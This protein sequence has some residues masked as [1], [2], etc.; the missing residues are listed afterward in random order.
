LIGSRP[1]N[2]GLEVVVAHFD[3]LDFEFLP[4][5]LPEARFTVYDKSG[6]Y[7]G[8]CVR[9][10]N[11]GREGDSY[12][13]HI[14]DNYDSLARRT[15][16]IQDDVLSHRPDALPFVAEIISDRSRFHQFPCTWNGGES[17]YRRVVRG[18]LCDLHTLGRPDMIKI[19]CEE[20]CIDV[21]S[22]YWTETCAFFSATDEAIRTRGREFYE[23]VR[24]WL[25]RSKHH[26][27]ALEHIWKLVF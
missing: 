24:N 26:G 12:L 6:K 10:K 14:I 23:K 17:A 21:P 18:G 3:S 22:E 4:P 11:N 5:L 15:V 16:F 2:I 1:K 8:E 25:L 9:L 19:A 13:A 7:E 20:L 27:Y